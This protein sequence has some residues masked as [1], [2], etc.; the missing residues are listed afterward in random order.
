MIFIKNEII[1][2]FQNRQKM[3][4]PKTHGFISYIA[5]WEVLL[6][7]GKKFKNG[8]RAIGC[9]IFVAS[10]IFVAIFNLAAIV[11]I[12]NAFLCYD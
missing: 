7:M 9:K 10:K 6:Q 4:D 12:F 11:A 8:N 2:I 3:N 1:F 5:G